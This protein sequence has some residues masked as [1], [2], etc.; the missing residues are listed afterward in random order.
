MAEGSVDLVG[1]AYGEDLEQGSGRSLGYRLL[2]PAIP[3]RWC[4]EVESLA[5]RLQAAPYPDHWP[6]E[7]LFCSVLLADGQR[8]VAVARYGLSDHTSGKRRGG[9]ELVGVV[10]PATLPVSSALVLYHWLQKLRTAEEDLHNLGGRHSLAEV[11]DSASREPAPT[12]SDGL[13]GPVPVL[14]VRLWQEGSFLFA[15]GTPGDPD[16]HLRLLDLA[17]TTHWQWLP[18]VGP[19][20]PLPSYAQRGPLIAWTPHLAGIAVKLDR[21]ESAP[22]LPRRRSRR[23]P[24]AVAFLLVVLIVLLGVNLWYVQKIHKAVTEIPTPEALAPSKTEPAKKDR[25]VSEP[26]TEDEHDRFARALYDVL[27][28][29]GGDREWKDDRAALLERYSG[30]VRRHPDLAVRPDNERGKLAIAATSVLAGRS[31]ERIEE[32]VR[33]GLTGKGFSDRLIK[34]ACEHVREQLAGEIKDSR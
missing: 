33:R 29:K 28:E 32:S 26:K 11:L 1:F 27:V 12:R 9:L 34:A 14:P 8:L 6:T 17:G 24:V 2:A 22:L 30:L 20:F 31:S 10:G 4:G 25:V 19:D 21:K 23:G 3:L 15:A 5:R 13:F 16:H 18:L 7:D